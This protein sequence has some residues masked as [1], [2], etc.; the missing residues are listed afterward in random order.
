MLNLNSIFYLISLENRIY[1]YKF[2][3]KKNLKLEKGSFFDFI[4]NNLR[5]LEYMLL[6]SFITLPPL[7]ALF[8]SMLE[9]SLLI[10][11]IV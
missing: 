2:F 5:F 10:F 9:I 3:L 6:M 11:D 8:L 4:K 7:S 1:I